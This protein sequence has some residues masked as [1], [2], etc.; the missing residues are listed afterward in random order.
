[1]GIRDGDVTG[2]QTCALPIFLA[3]RVVALQGKLDAVMEEYSRNRV[4]RFEP[5]RSPTPFCQALAERARLTITVPYKTENL[6]I[7]FTRFKI[8]RASGRESA[9]DSE[10]SRR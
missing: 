5:P 1:D 4:F 9:T 10:R 6:A 8:G 7:T 3:A 2:V